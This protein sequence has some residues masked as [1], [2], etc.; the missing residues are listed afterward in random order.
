MRVEIHV[1]TID[2][3]TAAKEAA[4]ARLTEGDELLIVVDAPRAPL[5]QDRKAAS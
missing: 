4:E 3:I 1:A 2:D 5:F